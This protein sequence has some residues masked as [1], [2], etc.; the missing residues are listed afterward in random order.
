[1]KMKSYHLQKSNE[2][3]GGRVKNL[4]AGKRGFLDR[5]NDEKNESKNYTD[6]IQL[7]AEKVYSDAFMLMY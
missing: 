1:M 4:M 2:C 5:I 6:A 3:R 7:D